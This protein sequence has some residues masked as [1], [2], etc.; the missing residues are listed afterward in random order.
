MHYARAIR[1]FNDQTSP[2]AGTV[3]VVQKPPSSNL[4][5]EDSSCAFN[6]CT[7]CGSHFSEILSL[8]VLETDDLELFYE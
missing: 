6:V 5:Q 7:L 3:V 8:F 4:T 1:L 2:L